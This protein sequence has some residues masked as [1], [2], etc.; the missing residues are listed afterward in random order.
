MKNGGSNFALIRP[1]HSSHLNRREA[2]TF[3]LHY[4][5]E[6]P[7]VVRKMPSSRSL[8]N[9]LSNARSVENTAAVRA[10]KCLIPCP[11][12]RAPVAS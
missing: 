11:S 10:I 3:L 12:S 6:F 8:S 7:V 2:L 9:I 4:A 1:I 5:Q